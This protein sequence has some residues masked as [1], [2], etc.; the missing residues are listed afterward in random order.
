M[1]NPIF[2]ICALMILFTTNICAKVR[3]EAKLDGLYSTI[4][5]EQ[6]ELL[7]HLPNSYGL[8][9]TQRYP[10]LF[11]TDGLRNF[12]HV[13]GTL[14][15]LNQSHEA[16]EMI[17]VA[18]NNTHRTRDLTPT[19]NESFNQWGI[20]G[21]ADKFLSFIEKEL[22]PH[23]DKQYRTNN[24]RV[25]SGHSLGGLF[26]IYA[27]HTK[28][29]LFQAYFAFSPSLWW[30][31]GIVVQSAKQ[32]YTNN[33]N[34]N[35]YLYL[36]LADEDGQMLTSYQEYLTIIE[37][38]KPQGFH[39]NSDINTRENHS[40]SAMVGNNIALTNLYRL[41]QCDSKALA[42]G[43]DAIKSCFSELSQRYN[44]QLQPNYTAYSNAAHAAQKSGATANTID[45]YRAAIKQ[46]PYIS[47]A[48]F[49]LAYVYHSTNQDEKA[50]ETIN[51]AL[52]VSEQENAEN[53]KIKALRD[54]IMN[55]PKA[56]K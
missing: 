19:Y 8:N 37:Q 15:L 10:V 54:F 42:K 22:I 47:D 41:L 29:Q 46:F 39:Y 48:Y 2:F 6:R 27:L 31:D 11:L 26:S 38:H 23:I 51:K 1:R 43:I 25:L 44:A 3:G 35:R 45:I 52:S 14:D 7:V 18:I 33:S 53:N 16:Q 34:L 12:N 40:T 21:G 36:N 17:V 9:K 56:A 28:P 5:S 32:F 13:S 30:H 20:S 49:R 4:L 55:N 24:F 50:L